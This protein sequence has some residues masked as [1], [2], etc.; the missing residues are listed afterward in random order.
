[1]ERILRQKAFV[2][3]GCTHRRSLKRKPK[4]IEYFESSKRTIKSNGCKIRKSKNSKARKS[5]KH[6]QQNYD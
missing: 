4:F 2:S 3:F 6:D 1:M 5:K